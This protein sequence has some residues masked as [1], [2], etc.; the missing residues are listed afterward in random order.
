MH[1][2]NRI[3]DIAAHGLKVAAL[4]KNGGTMTDAARNFAALFSLAALP[5]GVLLLGVAAWWKRR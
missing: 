2:R 1:V 4:L 5:L 3:L